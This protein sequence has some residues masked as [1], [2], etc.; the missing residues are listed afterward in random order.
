VDWS[1]GPV[2]RLLGGSLWSMVDH[3]QGWQPRIAGEITTRHYMAQNLIAVVQEGGA[4]HDGPHRALWWPAR[5]RDEAGGEEEETAKL[6]LSVGQLGAWRS[7]ENGSTRC[8][9]G[10]WPSG[11]F[12]RSGNRAERSRGGWSS[13]ARWCSINLPVT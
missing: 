1:H 8:G 11:A 9:V 2:D 5:W 6:E 12:N 10:L 7:E 13:T 4:G 3:G